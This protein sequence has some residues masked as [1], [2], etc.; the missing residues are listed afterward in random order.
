M[1]SQ[2]GNQSGCPAGRRG[3]QTVWDGVDKG[4]DKGSTADSEME[5]L[6]D[7]VGASELPHLPKQYV[8]CQSRGR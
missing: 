7:V 3:L 4:F 1:A 5:V 8:S 6:S 2:L